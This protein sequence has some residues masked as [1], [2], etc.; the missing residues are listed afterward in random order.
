MARTKGAVLTIIIIVLMANF[1][2][3]GCRTAET[4]IDHQPELAGQGIFL[5]WIDSHSLEIEIDGSPRSFGIGDNVDLGG[6]Q[7][8][9]F[10]SFTYLENE[11]QPVLLSIKTIEEESPKIFEAAGIYNGQIDSH[12]V[13]MEINGEATAFALGDEVS[14]ENLD[15]G[16]PV[17][18]TYI[19]K[20]GRFVL[21]SVE[22]ADLPQGD[23]MDILT[24]E[25]VFVGQIDARSVELEI[26]RVFII[27]AGIDIPELNQGDLVAFTFIE[28][29]PKAELIGI[30]SV[31]EPLEGEYMHGTFID[32]VDAQSMEIKYFQA[33]ELGSD[34]SLENI[35]DG[36]EV[37][38]TYSPGPHRPVLTSLSAR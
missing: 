17:D 5:G 13:E 1:L 3:S 4:D 12:S 10:I 31:D 15:E 26:S 14:V 9:T 18:I 6:I 22:P 19:E 16:M 21:L 30:Q 33:F 25:G 2:F 11:E 27:D 28:E 23:G 36:S 34:L 32:W 29:G 37:V 20:Q 8:G 35:E 7:E 24:G 38:F